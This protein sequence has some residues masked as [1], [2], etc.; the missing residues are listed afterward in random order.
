MGER[1]RLFV[2]QPQ[3]I[4]FR[5]KDEVARP[6]PFEEALINGG[7]FES[8]S[9]FDRQNGTD[10]CDPAPDRWKN[11]FPAR[12]GGDHVRMRAVMIADGE[13]ALDGSFRL[14]R[15]RFAFVL[16]GVRSIAQAAVCVNGQHRDSSADVVCHQQMF[17]VR[18]QERYTG[19]APPEAT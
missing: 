18:R 1:R 14:R 8:A 15:A 7:S 3:G 9:R 17:T 19:P 16:M 12:I 10:R 5:R 4:T 2:N 6:G 11:V 13:T